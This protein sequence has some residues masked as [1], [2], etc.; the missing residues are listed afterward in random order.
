[1]LPIVLFSVNS[2]KCVDKHICGQ[3]FPR[4]I[5]MVSRLERGYVVFCLFSFSFGWDSYPAAL[6]AHS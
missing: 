1:M 5:S 3:A 6:I 4:G 2:G